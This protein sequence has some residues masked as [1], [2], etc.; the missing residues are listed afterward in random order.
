M[1]TAMGFYIYNYGG[2]LVRAGNKWIMLVGALS[3]SFDTMMRLI[4]QK[5]KA[6]ERD[7]ADK[8]IAIA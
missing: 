2:L 4:Y 6:T 5:Y 3:S 8:G 7:M 1:C